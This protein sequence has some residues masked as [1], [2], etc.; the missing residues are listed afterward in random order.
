MERELQGKVALI[1]GASRGIGKA[2]AMR[3]AQAGAHVVIN[4]HS[5]HEEAEALKAELE[6]QY[7]IRALCLQ[8]DIREGAQVEQLFGSLMGQFGQLDILINNA[9]IYRDKLLLRMSEEDWD[10]VISTNLKGLFN[11]SKQAAR[12][13]LRQKSGRIVNIS[14]VVGQIGNAGQANYATSKAG[15]VGFTKSL[16]LELAPRQI[17]VNAVAP[18]YIHSEMTDSLSEAVHAE[19]LKKIPYGR[20]GECAEVAEMVLFLASERCQYITGQTFN[21]DGGMVMR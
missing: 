13:M 4:Y 17:A 9:G 20:Y 2:C 16:A 19:T 8:A 21:V 1:T 10:E 7:D 12:I 15:I 11:C 18:G 3:L 5:Q 14:S 6:S